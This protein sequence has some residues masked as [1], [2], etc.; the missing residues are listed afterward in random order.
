MMK[1]GTRRILDQHRNDIRELFAES[2]AATLGRTAAEI[3]DD[4]LGVGDFKAD[5]RIEL[6]LCDGSTMCFR[7]AFAVLDAGR[8]IVGIFTEHCGYYCFGMTDLRLHVV[9]DGKTVV[10][11]AW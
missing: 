11:H 7:Y 2:L 6:T 10:R 9:R 4:G 8:R 5:E 3:R 1:A